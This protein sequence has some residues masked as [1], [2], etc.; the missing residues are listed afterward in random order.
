MTRF[1]APDPSFAPLPAAVL[2]ALGQ[3]QTVEAIKRLRTATGIGLK[4]AREAIGRHLADEPARPRPSI[5]AMA[6]LPFAVGAAPVKGDTL[7]AI[8]RMREKGGRVGLA[9]L[10]R[11][12]FALPA[13]AASRRISHHPR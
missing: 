1:A 10:A 4:E 3:G 8:R 12:V 5:A 7:E 2:A 11:R 13:E 9:L 6:T